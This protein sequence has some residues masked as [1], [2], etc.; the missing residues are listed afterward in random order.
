MDRR[1]QNL[2]ES[3]ISYLKV[4][5]GLSLNTLKSY[6]LDLYQFLEKRKDF[7][8]LSSSRAG[9]WLE[10]L[11][12]E[13]KETSTLA[14]KLSSL[15]MFYRFLLQEGKIKENPWEG[16]SSPRR[17]RK[18]PS[19]LSFKEV[20]RLLSLPSPG[21][22][23]GLRDKAILEFL[24]A[25]GVRV[26]ELVNLKRKDLN[27]KDRWVKVMGKGGKERLLPLGREASLWI[28]K[29]LK[30]LKE[31]RMEGEGKQSPLFLNRYGR[32]LSRITVW[33][34]IKKY[35]KDAGITKKISPH[36]LRHSFATHL[37]AQDA[38]LRSV[39]ELLGHRNISTTQIY[40]HITQ[41]RLKK[42]YRRYHPRA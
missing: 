15:R 30:E 39:Q 35:A 14:R 2:V 25:T 34:R 10:S 19:Y 11:R 18:L 38:D 4:E 33:K 16:F 29:Y 8:T 9:E 22:F 36:T 41:E 27:L 3:F 31:K 32:K 20:E 13:G 12:R 37:L 23:V 42:I 26:S 5:R 24:Y 17:G 21:T 28:R 7:F 6:R 1:T 40:T